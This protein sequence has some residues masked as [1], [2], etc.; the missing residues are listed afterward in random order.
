MSGTEKPVP[1]PVIDT[2]PRFT[3]VIRYFRGV[4]YLG[5]VAVAAF[6]PGLMYWF[7]KYQPSGNSGAPLRAAMKAA[8]VVGLLAGFL[9][10]YTQSSMRFLGYKENAR[11][12][13]MFREEYARLKKEGKTMEGYSMLSPDLQ[14]VAARYST[15]SILNVGLLPWFNIVSHPYH[16][17]SEG[18]IPKEDL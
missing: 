17:Q 8:G 11:E 3:R 15:N 16:G 7:E 12:I 6:G 14:A 5:G 9:H 4:D 18:V 10:M 13:K 1:Y 2:D